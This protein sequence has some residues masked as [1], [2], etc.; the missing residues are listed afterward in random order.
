[1][2]A[3]YKIYLYQNKCKFRHKFN[4][5]LDEHENIIK[6]YNDSEYFYGEPVNFEGKEGYLINVYKNG[7]IFNFKKNN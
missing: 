2:D 3:A 1:M 6:E 7:Q 4:F 5:L